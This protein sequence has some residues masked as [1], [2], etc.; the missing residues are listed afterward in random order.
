MAPAMPFYA[1]YLFLA[2]R[3]K[4]EA[5]SVHLCAWPITGDV[6][7]DL[8]DKMKEVRM[9]VTQGLEARTKA[10]IKVRQPLSEIFIR[11]TMLPDTELL[12]LIKDELNV[13]QISL[14]GVGED[15]TPKITLITE[16]TPE[17]LAEGAV[18]EVMRAVQDM[19]KD[20]GME[21]SD[22]IKLVISTDAQGEA[23]VV[24]HQEL[25]Q[26]TVGATDVE[27]GIV[28]GMT[29]TAG[30]HTFTIAIEKI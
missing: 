14:D 24:S 15:T 25:L 11:T 5:E 4:S 27:F 13:K 23:A 20:A 22:R 8:I 1:E 2:V 10:N 30:D 7:T 3:D 16:L 29:V 28:F 19:R 6:N 17:L 21:P 26:K 18:R 9:F 12:D